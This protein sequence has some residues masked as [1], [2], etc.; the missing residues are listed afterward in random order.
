MADPRPVP[1]EVHDRA[2][3]RLAAMIAEHE[4]RK[5]SI[6]VHVAGVLAKLGE[7]VRAPSRD[8]WP[9]GRRR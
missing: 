4:R 8:D 1:A 5:W 3:L 7:Q 2:D 9:E 6:V